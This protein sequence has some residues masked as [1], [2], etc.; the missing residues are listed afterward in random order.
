LTELL[1]YWENVD[2]VPDEQISA[3]REFLE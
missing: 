3:V 2:R 1:D